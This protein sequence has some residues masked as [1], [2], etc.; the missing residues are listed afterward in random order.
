[1]IRE[2]IN[3]EEVKRQTLEYL[4][5]HTSPDCLIAFECACDLGLENPID[6]DPKSGGVLAPEF[7]GFVDR[8]ANELIAEEID[9]LSGLLDADGRLTVHRSMIVEESWLQAELNPRDLGVCWTWNEADAIAHH[10][11]NFEGSTDGIEIRLRGRVHCD[12]VDWTATVALNA[13]DDYF[14]GTENEIRLKLGSLVEVDRVEWRRDWRDDFA[15]AIEVAR[16]P[17]L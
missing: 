13:G 6:Y 5:V 14:T 12:Q 7:L 3:Y 1:M 8:R 17:A 11:H 15:E 2:R 4:M 9:K 16:A 10:A